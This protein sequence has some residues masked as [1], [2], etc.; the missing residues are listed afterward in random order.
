MYIYIYIYMYMSAYRTSVCSLVYTFAFY[1]YTATT[2]LFF[3]FCFLAL[4]RTHM[5]PQFTTR[6]TDWQYKNN[7]NNTKVKEKSEVQCLRFFVFFCF[8]TQAKYHLKPSRLTR[9]QKI[10]LTSPKPAPP[11]STTI[12]NHLNS[13]DQ[14][15]QIKLSFFPKPPKPIGG[16]FVN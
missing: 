2:T 5:W 15:S 3:P 13:E 1:S 11:L 16:H 7:N 8:E 12:T 10:P 14:Q 6:V 9:K 4:G